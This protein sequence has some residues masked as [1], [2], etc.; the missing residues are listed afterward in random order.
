MGSAFPCRF[1]A[2]HSLTNKRP[3]GAG[4]TLAGKVMAVKADSQNLTTRARAHVMKRLPLLSSDLH[5][6]A[7]VRLHHKAEVG[8][9]GV[10]Y[11]L[12]Y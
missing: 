10:E 9:E 11:N 12:N 8:G 4:R 5:V 2:M 3:R 6:S 1:K 7:V